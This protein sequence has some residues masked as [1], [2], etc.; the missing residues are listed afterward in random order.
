MFICIVSDLDYATY[1]MYFKMAADWL[2]YRYIKQNVRM[3]CKQSL[4]ITHIQAKKS[5]YTVYVE[6]SFN[7]DSEVQH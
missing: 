2:G 6:F 1:Y 4:K 7:A 3:Y 5:P